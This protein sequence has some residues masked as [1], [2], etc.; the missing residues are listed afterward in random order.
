MNFRTFNLKDKEV[1]VA[2]TARNELEKDFILVAACEGKQV[3]YSSFRFD[4]EDTCKLT[5]IVVTDRNYISTGV[6]NAMFKCME[7]F[8]YENGI[9]EING[10][11]I[12]RGYKD[13]YEL[14]EKFYAKQGMKA[15]DGSQNYFD[16]DEIYKY[17][18]EQGEDYHVDLTIDGHAF[19]ILAK[20]N[21]EE[22]DFFSSRYEEKAL[23]I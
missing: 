23:E 10:Y 16:R 13:C 15:C 2:I 22:N 1:D 5:R 3:G 7:Q 8:C 6:G 14:A 11:F 4:D 18:R 9:R 12:P 20:Y 17:A 21:F 19:D